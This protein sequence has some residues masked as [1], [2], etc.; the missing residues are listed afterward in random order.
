MANSTYDVI[1]IG[2]GGMGSRRRLRAYTNRGHR[3][4]GLEQF[5]LVHDRG[6]SHGQSRIIRTAYFEHPSYV[7][8]VRRLL[9]RWYH[10]E[11]R[12]GRHLLTSAS[13]LSIGTPESDVIRGVQQAACE[14][15]LATDSLNADQM[16]QRFPMFCF[17]P[18]YVGVLEH[19]A[20]FL[21]VEECVRTHIRW[22]D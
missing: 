4:L 21:Y 16:R 6:S 7:P 22:S 8:L 11:Q 3:V 19:E 9:R 10:L 2:V 14:H 18:E 13:C 12:S 20:G 5:P 1:I 17:G 15:R